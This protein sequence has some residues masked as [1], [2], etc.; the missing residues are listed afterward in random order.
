[1]QPLEGVGVSPIIEDASLRCLNTPMQEPVSSL[2]PFLECIHRDA[3]SYFFYL[4]FFAF[5]MR[6]PWFK[7]PLATRS[8]EGPPESP[9]IEPLITLH[10]R[11]SECILSRAN[12]TPMYLEAMRICPDPNIVDLIIGRKA[13]ASTSMPCAGP[14]N[15]GEGQ[16]AA[17]LGSK[18]RCRCSCV[19][20]R[21]LPTA[22]TPF[23]TK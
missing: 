21:C 20:T 1:M 9:E 18:N 14:R 12:K 7:L 6:R 10:A 2:A 23:W 17:G 3:S 19:V 5:F 11:D 13:S 4:I 15:F 16:K 22:C 8:S